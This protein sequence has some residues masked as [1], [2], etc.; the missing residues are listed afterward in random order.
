MKD[1]R[2]MPVQ[3]ALEWAFQKECAQL[4][5]EDNTPAEE[6]GFGF[7]MEHVLLQRIKLGTQVDTSRGR[8]Y[9]HHDADIIA[10]IVAGHPIRRLAL[11][12]AECARLGVTPDWMPDAEPKIQP[13]DWKGQGASHSAKTDRGDVWRIIEITRPY[14]DKRRTKKTPKTFETLICPVVTDP[15]PLAIQAARREYS[16]WWTALNMVRTHLQ[17]T[18]QLTNVVVTDAMP[19][20]SPWQRKT[21]PVKEIA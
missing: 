1:K 6:R 18:D 12:M 21:K 16:N 2:F 11:R 20:Q 19:P 13:V 7:G 9:P 17:A 15:H 3:Q 5:L 14:K 10:A 8:S 4:D